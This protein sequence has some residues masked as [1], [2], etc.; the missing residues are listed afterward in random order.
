MDITQFCLT[1]TALL[2]GN[3][4]GHALKIFTYQLSLYID[5]VSRL[6]FIRHLGGILAVANIRG[7]GEYGETWHKGKDFLLSFL[8]IT[9][10]K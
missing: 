3:S 2:W 6:I 4:R 1:D 10:A 9:H 8:L 5:S 7:G